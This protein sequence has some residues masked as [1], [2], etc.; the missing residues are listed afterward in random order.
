[1]EYLE[2]RTVFGLRK[3]LK[4]CVR[5]RIGWTSAW[6]DEKVNGRMVAVRVRDR[7]FPVVYVRNELRVTGF[8]RVSNPG[9]YLKGGREQVRNTQIKGSSFI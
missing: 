5:R 8:H 4:K 6:M 7:D 9:S 3:V 2:S 1:M